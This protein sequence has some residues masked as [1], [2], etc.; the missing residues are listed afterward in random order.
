MLVDTPTGF[1]NSLQMSRKIASR[2]V[3]LISLAALT[4]SSGGPTNPPAKKF[5]RCIRPMAHTLLA[6]CGPG[7]PSQ[8]VRVQLEDLTLLQAT[9]RHSTPL[10][11][12]ANRIHGS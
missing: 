5:L 8:R 1:V 10:G 4:S 2:Q 3:I 11:S 12:I 6:Q 7:G 9:N